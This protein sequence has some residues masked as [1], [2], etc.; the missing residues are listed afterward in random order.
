MRH[1]QADRNLH[2]SRS[3]A[4]RARLGVGFAAL[5][6]GVSF[7]GTASAKPFE[8][9]LKP[10]P[11]VS[12]LSS[13]SWGVAGVLPRDLSNGIEDAKGAAVPPGWFYW[14]GE[15][16]KAQDGKHHMFMSNAWLLLLG[17]A[18]LPLVRRRGSAKKD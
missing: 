5:M 3:L 1:V 6:A 13:A 9:Y 14:D 11:I 17:L 8:D 4:V 16:I 10:T 18:I 7:A 12:P 15:I 2:W